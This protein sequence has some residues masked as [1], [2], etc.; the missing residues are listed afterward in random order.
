MTVE[1]QLITAL[2]IFAAASMVGIAG[3][4]AGPKTGHERYVPAPEK[5]QSTIATVLE[6][7]QRGEPVGE[8]KGTSA[9]RIY[10]VDSFRRDGQTLE[11]FEI[12]GEVAGHTQRTYLLKL[13]LANPAAE[14]KV[15]FAVLGIDPLWVYRHEDLELLA[16]WE[17]KMPEPATKPIKRQP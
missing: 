6:S 15:R 16:H 3:C 4:E 12:L 1:R 17:H 7:W 8:I 2:R 13:T 10:L 5:A 9:P 11:H 14:E